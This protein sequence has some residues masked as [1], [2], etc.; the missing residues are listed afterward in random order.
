MPKQIAISSTTTT[1]EAEA[2]AASAAVIDEIAM[3]VADEE[4]AFQQSSSSV[5]TPLLNN[6]QEEQQQQQATTEQ[7]Q[8]QLANDGN[9]NSNNDDETNQK[10]PSSSSTEKKVTIKKSNKGHCQ[11][12][13]TTSSPNGTGGTRC[14]NL[15]I[16]AGLCYRH[17][18]KSLL[19]PR[20]TCKIP[21]CTNQVQRGGVC[22]KHGAKVKSCRYENCTKN[23]VRGGY[24]CRHGK[25][26]GVINDDENKK[27]CVVE[28]CNNAAMVVKNKKS[29]GDQQ[30]TGEEQ[31][32][33]AITV[34]KSGL[35]CKRHAIKKVN[36]DGDVLCSERWCRNKVVT[37]CESGGEGGG[38]G[39]RGD[40]NKGG[41]EKGVGCCEK[42]KEEG[43][44][45]CKKHCQTNH[46]HHHHHDGHH[47]H[48][49]KSSGKGKFGHI[50]VEGKLLLAPCGQCIGCKTS[51]CKTCVKCT[52]NPKKRCEG[53]PCSNPIW[54]DRDEYNARFMNR[55]GGGGKKDEEDMKK[56]EGSLVGGNGE[57]ASDNVEEDVIVDV[58]DE[59]DV[60][61]HRNA[62]NKA[63]NV[64][65]R[66]KPMNGYMRFTAEISHEVIAEFPELNGKELVSCCYFVCRVALF[67]IPYLTLFTQYPRNH[68]PSNFRRDGRHWMRT[69]K[70]SIVTMPRRRWTNSRNN[71]V[72]IR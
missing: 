12:L 72:K 29:S 36:E 68:S 30:V 20:P 16:K 53:R 56:G 45:L 51:P 52:S 9:T 65:K 5:P 54:L 35:Y 40:D 42:G 19:P 43:V 59:S 39:E 55:I 24:C 31:K 28:H 48:P 27:K 57:E 13:F 33:Q 6:R 3:A 61:K 70:K 66:M 15:A 1:A 14:T 41:K 23:A 11:H 8:L 22:C 37:D 60:A 4:A 71:V 69:R 10:Q 64:P 26:M 38:G 7:Q 34:A 50:N 18:A 67:D 21:N 44:P 32:V 2:E 62:A 47:H 63:A 49:K 25:L 17:G 46:H 58:F